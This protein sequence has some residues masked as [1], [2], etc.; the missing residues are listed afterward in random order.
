MRMYATALMTL[1]SI[2]FAN[3]AQEVYDKAPI[4]VITPLLSHEAD[5]N[6]DTLLIRLC[7]LASTMTAEQRRHLQ[8]LIALLLKSGENPL[9]ENLSGC[10]AM[11]YIN[12]MP[13]LMQ[14][15]GK[16]Y[17]LPRELTLRLPYETA[18]LLRYMR[19]RSAQQRHAVN[20]GS[21]A[22]ML[23]RYC[24]PAFPRAEKLFRHFMEQDSLRNIPDGALGDCLDFMRVAEPE[25]TDQYIN[26]L[27]YWE[28]GEHFLEEL[29][30]LLLRDLHR[31]NWPVNPGNLRLALLKLHSMLPTSQ[32][33]MIDC[34]AAGPMIQLLELLTAQEGIRAMNDVRKC[35]ESHDPN[36]AQAAL[37]LQMKLMGLTPPD[38]MDVRDESLSEELRSIRST[39]L[40]DAALRYCEPDAI[41]ADMLRQAIECCKQHGMPLRA[42]LMQALQEGRRLPLSAAAM[43]AISTAYNEIRESSPSVVLLHYLLE[44]PQLLSA[45]PQS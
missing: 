14:E 5:V 9:Q 44:H 20:P 27:N 15:L 26:G 41:T 29:P 8:P 39:L 31:L 18:A 17:R 45:P 40:T 2:C 12:G 28:H 43:P 10:N 16:E 3:G 25:K 7:R 30:G 34:D 13:E 4:E 42:E 11:F 36:L 37:R 22:Y 32:D 6:G 21:R 35:A 33:D 1:G 23:R 24:K 38:E 19:L